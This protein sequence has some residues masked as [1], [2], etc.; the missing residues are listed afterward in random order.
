MVN[1][2]WVLSV[3]ASVLFFSLP[4]S[5]GFVHQDHLLA[6]DS[7]VTLH[8][9]TGLNWMKLS[10]TSGMSINQVS[11]QFGAG[12]KFDGW[13]LASDLEV[14]AMLRAMMPTL[15]FTDNKMSGAP[16]YMGNSV[17]QQTLNWVTWMGVTL[18]DNPNYSYGLYYQEGTRTVL[19]SGVRQGGESHVYDDYYS[20][21]YSGFNWASSYYGVFMVKAADVIAPPDVEDVPVSSAGVL[22]GFGLML[23]S[24]GVRRKF[25]AKNNYL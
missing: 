5:A 1:R 11:S 15:T 24:G 7:K 10:V 18:K 19:M 20:G 14:E 3:I 16:I 2:A 9:E 13:R 12:G 8:E 17:A 4:A 25:F 6:G 21:V 22:F 23:L